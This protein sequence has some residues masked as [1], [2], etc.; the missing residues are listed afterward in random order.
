ME[1]NLIPDNPILII[2]DEEDVIKSLSEPT[3]ESWWLQIGIWM[4]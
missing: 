4:N 1:T 2:D 3:P